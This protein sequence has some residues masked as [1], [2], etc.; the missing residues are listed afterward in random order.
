MVHD[1]PTEMRRLNQ[2]EDES[3]KLWK[4]V[5]DLSLNKEMLQDAP[6]PKALS[7]PAVHRVSPELLNRTAL[8]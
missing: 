4:V 2:L 1:R 5:A 3:V 8:L 7:K 6:S